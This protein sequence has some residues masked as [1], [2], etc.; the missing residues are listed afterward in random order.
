[1]KIKAIVFG[2]TGMVGEGVLFE[3]LSHASVESVLVLGRKP[4]GVEH[5]KLKELLH[6]DFF[7]YSAME[8]HITGYNACF[9][10]LGVSSVG[11][12]ERDYSRVTHHLTIQAA[13]TL[14][15]LNSDMTFCYVSGAG[16]DSSE[17][18]RIM[19]ARVK[20]KTENDLVRLPFKAV[21]LFRPG[22]IKP[23]KGLRNA[24]ALSKMVGLLFPVWKALFPRYVCTLEE[25]GLSMIQAAMKGYP[26]RVLESEDIALLAHTDSV[27]SA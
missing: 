8:E 2:A 17:K 16:T 23:T 21:Y 3:A 24:F 1:M 18:G 14:S 11:M 27:D 22:Y 10:C 15:R 6:N 13:T 4:C 7:D 12:N 20:G 26:K 25:L 5:P 9:F 19:W